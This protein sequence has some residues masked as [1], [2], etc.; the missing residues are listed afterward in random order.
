MRARIGCVSGSPKR[1]LNSSTLGVPSGCDHDAGV[2]EAEV[3]RAFA[4][5]RR[6]RGQHHLAHDALVHRRGHDRRGRIGAHAAGVR[7]VVAVAQALVVLRRRERQHG[8][9]VDHRDEAGFLALEEFLD[10]DARRRPRRSWPANMSSRGL[11]G[12]VGGRAD[13]HALAG[14]EAVGLDDE[15][16]ALC[17]HPGC[18]EV[19]AR[20]KVA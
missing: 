9:A 5:E 14:G 3:R 1:Q 11:H 20:V 8:A 10:D 17:A 7:A 2:Q 15:R 13:H 18:V 12:F 19:S 4:R 6:D 16:R